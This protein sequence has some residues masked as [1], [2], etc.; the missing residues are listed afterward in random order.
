M[1]GWKKIMGLQGVLPRGGCGASV[2]GRG[3]RPV[4][5]GPALGCVPGKQQDEC[6]ESTSKCRTLPLARDWI[7]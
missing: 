5:S 7:L 6:R 2:M 4:F 1:C 3:A